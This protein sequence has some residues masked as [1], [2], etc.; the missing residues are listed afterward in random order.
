M[1]VM[2]CNDLKHVSMVGNVAR[3]VKACSH[4]STQFGRQ[5]VECAKYMSM[6]YTLL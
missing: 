3:F 1:G 4:L 5:V 6:L 2:G